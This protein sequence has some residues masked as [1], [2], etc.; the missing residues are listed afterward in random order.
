MPASP[1]ST[2]ESAPGAA[3]RRGRRRLPRILVGIGIALTLLIGL[4]AVGG[5]LLV[6]RYES[7]FNR[8]TLLAPG[9]RAAGQGSL[10]GPLNLL[11]IGSDYRTWSP[12]AGQR[13]DTIII[14]HIREGLDHIYL[15]LDS[16]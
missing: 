9:A 4:V 6:R 16:A 3:A 15:H 5:F 8:D 10:S 1:V 7:A 13:S 14:A 11:L 2:D 12:T